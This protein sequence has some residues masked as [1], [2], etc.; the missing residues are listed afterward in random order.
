MGVR[1]SS[2]ACP[3]GRVLHLDA[4]GRIR[5][6]CAKLGM[7]IGSKRLEGTELK[8]PIGRRGDRPWYGDWPA[9]VAR[10][11]AVDVV[12]PREPGAMA[13]VGSGKAWWKRRGKLPD[14]NSFVVIR[15]F[16]LRNFFI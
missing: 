12:I 13:E 2:G 6:L 7:I 4:A 5:T 9:S 11:G 8:V 15:R 3:A 1:K 14:R 10:C 16:E